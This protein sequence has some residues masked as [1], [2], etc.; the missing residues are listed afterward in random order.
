MPQVDALLRQTA[1]DSQRQLLVAAHDFAAALHRPGSGRIPRWVSRAKHV[2]Q[3]ESTLLACI[4]TI[5]TGTG[6]LQQMTQRRLA[7]TLDILLDPIRDAQMVEPEALLGK[8]SVGRGETSLLHLLPQERSERL[9]VSG[10]FFRTVKA[11]AEIHDV[12][13]P[14][15]SCPLQVDGV[16]AEALD[17]L[18]DVLMVAVDEFPA[19]LADHPVGPGGAIGVHATADAVGRFVDTARE[20]S[21]LQGKSCVESSDSRADDSDP[22][23]S[24]S[25][26]LLPAAH[27]GQARQPGDTN[28]C[29]PAPRTRRQRR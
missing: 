13:C 14:L 3:V 28:S 5:E 23:H 9:E 12:L 29:S 8:V 20:T 24:S 27:P 18:V 4:Q 22:G 11:I 10:Q 25:P 16:E 15:R 6:S 26:L 21:V 7:P 2:D 1:G 19:P 17:E